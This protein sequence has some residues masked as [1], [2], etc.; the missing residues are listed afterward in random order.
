MT[1]ANEDRSRKIEQHQASAASIIE[2]AVIY[3]PKNIKLKLEKQKDVWEKP[4]TSSSVYT[5]LRKAKDNNIVGNPH[6]EKK[7]IE[8]NEAFVMSEYAKCVLKE[9]W[10]SFEKWIE[11]QLEENLHKTGYCGYWVTSYVK[12]LFKVGDTWPWLE[13]KIDSLDYKKEMGDDFLKLVETYVIKTKLKK[14]LVVDFFVNMAIHYLVKLIRIGEGRGLQESE[15]Y[16]IFCKFKYAMLCLDELEVH[17]IE[18]IEK[19]IKIALKK[20]EQLSS[21]SR[22]MYS[23]YNRSSTGA[24][25]RSVFSLINWYGSSLGIVL[26]KYYLKQDKE[27]NDFYNFL[28]Q[29]YTSNIA[30]LFL[31][32]GA[33]GKR[34]SEEKERYLLA[35]MQEAFEAGYAEHL[36]RLD[37]P[38]CY[39]GSIMGSE[40]RDAVVSY[41]VNCI[42]GRWEAFEDL[43]V[44]YCDTKGAKEYAKAIKQIKKDGTYQSEN[45]A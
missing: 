22:E 31:Y 23:T 40:G 18:K 29:K 19:F 14:D 32:C 28:N 25:D 13:E 15:S 43:V 38:W 44:K 1:T 7:F 3:R 10:P 17:R 45:K 5:V 24:L 6:F 26:Q 37:N 42:K 4:R 11:D 30:E 36:E 2:E 27:N 21:F 12:E 41:V 33:I 34:M 20:F 35:Q 16:D 39:Y 9:R 8:S